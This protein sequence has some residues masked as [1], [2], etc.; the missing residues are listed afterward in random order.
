[1]WLAV[2]PES[3]F[4]AEELEGWRD[5]GWIRAGL[6]PRTLR[7]DTAGLVAAAIL[8]HLWGDLAPDSDP[9]GRC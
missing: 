2:G 6:G 3:G 5:A 1:L 8:L 7:A 4:D 9:R